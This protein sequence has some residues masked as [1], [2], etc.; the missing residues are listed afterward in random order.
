MTTPLI[1]KIRAVPETAVRL[2][3]GAQV[4]REDGVYVIS[5]DGR[6]HRV[7][8]DVY[9][10]AEAIVRALKIRDRRVEFASDVLEL[11]HD[12]EDLHLESLTNL[13]GAPKI[14]FVPSGQIASAYY[15]AMLP[16]DRMK[17]AGLA[18][19]DFT[20]RV[21][22]GKVMRYQILWIQLVSAPILLEIAKRAKEAGIKII[23][24]VD[25]KFDVIPEENPSAAVY[26]HEKQA[27]IWRLIEL[28]DLVTVS[29][30]NLADHVGSRAKRVQMLPNLIPAA[31]W[32]ERHVRDRD[33]FRILWAGSPTHKRDL[34]IVASALRSMLADHAGKVRFTLFG[35]RLPESLVAVRGFVDLMPFTD[36]EA[37]ADTLAGAAADLA[38]AP[39]EASEFNS[40][41][42]AVKAL[43]YGACGYP[44]LLS[45]VG[46]YPEV[47]KAGLPAGLVEDAHW[48]D[49]LEFHHGYW[50]S[51]T[52]ALSDKGKACQRWVRDNRC[53]LKTNAKQWAD[54][55]RELLKGDV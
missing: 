15:R 36:F 14:L 50:K 55:A 24:D 52:N 42:S 1:D 18:V 46:E 13:N 19:S 43:E 5:I 10:E 32:P 54:V 28:A 26:V 23:Y 17:E 3:L 39:L 45:P 6:V 20:A 48:R 30:K 25:D 53:L 9:D 47:V 16:A 35:D 31:A 33:I 41:K 34:A 38:I 22:L 11:R 7:T 44:M 21:D 49:A 40:A 51:G 37:Y 8:P 29:T 4:E 2:F 27:E 12:A